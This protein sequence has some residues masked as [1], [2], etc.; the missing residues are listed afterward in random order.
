MR[1]LL[2]AATLLT[3]LSLIGQ[4]RLQL[5]VDTIM[6]GPNLAGYTPRTL[7]WSH[8]SKLVYFDWKQH[9]D[10]IEENYETYVVGRDG[11]GLRKL[12]D[13]EAKHAPPTRGDWTRDRRMAVYTDGG[14]V[15]LY[16]SAAGKRRALTDTTEAESSARFTHDDKA[17]TF[18]RR[19]NLFLVSLTDGSLTQVTNI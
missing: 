5:S 7:R 19:N 8:D 2:L 18:V 4:E 10:P 1:R 14:D 15:F 13:E 16:D 6:R 11:K 3:A 17:V 12:T 9:T